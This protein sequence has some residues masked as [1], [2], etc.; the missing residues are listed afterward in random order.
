MNWINFILSL[1]VIASM[2]IKGVGLLEQYEIYYMSYFWWY[3]VPTGFF[4][5][6]AIAFAIGAV[7]IS[8]WGIVRKKPVFIPLALCYGFVLGNM[9]FLVHLYETFRVAFKVHCY[10]PFLP[11]ALIGLNL[12]MA[13]RSWKAWKRNQ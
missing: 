10:L 9:V 8:A 1:L 13:F 4:G 6:I 7:L 5:W 2:G 3:G 12:Y 11:F